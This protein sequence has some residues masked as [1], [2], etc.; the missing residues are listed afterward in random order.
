MKYIG[1]ANIHIK[2]E[3]GEKGEEEEERERGK[4][5]T[6]VDKSSLCLN[7]RGVVQLENCLLSVLV[8]VSRQE[9]EKRK[10]KK[11]ERTL[12]DLVKTV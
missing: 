3:E 10:R 2:K 8:K 6:R 9:R 7:Q 11:E 5:K 1:P 12:V 4:R